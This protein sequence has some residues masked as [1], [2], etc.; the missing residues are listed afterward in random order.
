MTPTQSLVQQ[1]FSY[2]QPQFD[3]V[4]APLTYMKVG[5]PAEVLLDL[6]TTQDIIEV[7]TFC[8]DQHIPVTVFGGASNVIVDDEGLQGVVVT[9]SNEEYQNTAGKSEET[10][11]I[12][13]GAGFKTA[14]FVR[15]TVDDGCTG[16]EYFLGVPGK[17]GGAI[18]NN[19][20]YLSDLI[21]QHVHR[22]Q[23]ITPQN[24]VKW[25]TKAECDFAYDYSIFHK[26]ADIIL[27]I[28][29]ALKKGDLVTSKEMIKEAT[30]YRAQT[31]P[32]GEPSSGCYF[33]NTPNTPELQKQ[34]PQFAERREVPSAFL[35]DQAGL[36]GEK[37]GDVE[38][39]HKHAAFFINKGKGTSKDLKQ[40]AEIVK[41]RIQD[42]FH[43]EL[44][45]EVFFL[46]NK[47]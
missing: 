9:L 13:A 6:K 40:L 37:I 45:E 7:V 28:E 25:L 15:Q 33:R 12:R 36:K 34:F 38:V 43:V 46:E 1:K 11:I 5:G 16:L 26:T 14:L 8:Q 32:L 23:V 20:H 2:L 10:T 21:G 18:Y 3:F 44:R 17:L 35:I 27:M 30:L 42:K 24:E 22:V 47:S 39:S 41:Q 29:F 4:L 19:A 31:Q